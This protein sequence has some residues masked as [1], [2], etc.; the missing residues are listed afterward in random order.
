MY[1]HGEND[2]RAISNRFQ[3]VFKSFSNRFQNDFKTILPSL[4]K[5]FRAN[6]GFQNQAA[7]FQRQEIN[8]CAQK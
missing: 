8:R 2:S 6:V 4:D 5:L 1:H 7:K 3:N